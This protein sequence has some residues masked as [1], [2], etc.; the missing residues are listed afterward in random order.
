VLG[1]A[2]VA[3]LYAIG[4]RFRP[5][6]VD[7]ERS[8]RNESTE[9]ILMG[10]ACAY[11]GDSRKVR[12]MT[13]ADPAALFAGIAWEDIYPGTLG[14]IKTCGHL[15]INDVLRSDAASIAF[16]DTFSVSASPGYLSK[17]GSQSLLT[18]I[19]NNAVRVGSSKV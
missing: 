8:L 6:F 18:A 7:E 5:A 4:E 12:K 1:S 19:R 9:G 13:A 3:S 11:D 2:A 16:G 15:S 10:M 17:G 14:R